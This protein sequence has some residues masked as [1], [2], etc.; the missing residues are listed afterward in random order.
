VDAAAAAIQERRH[1]KVRQVGFVSV[2]GRGD[3]ITN[4]GDLSQENTSFDV[5]AW[6]VRKKEVMSL[7]F[8]SLVCGSGMFDSSPRSSIL[9]RQ[10]FIA[11]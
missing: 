7:L 11:A 6:K 8:V 5:Q 4:L 2:R 1:G 10:N 3:A 9:F